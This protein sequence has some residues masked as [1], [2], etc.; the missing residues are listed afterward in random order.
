[1]KKEHKWILIA[2]IAYSCYVTAYIFN[3]SDEYPQGAEN[4]VIS[5]ETSF[6][7][8]GRQTVDI[9][10]R[11]Q[12]RD[13]APAGLRQAVNE[14]TE[15][16]VRIKT[17]TRID[18]VLVPDTVYISDGCDTIH[19]SKTLSNEWIQVAIHARRDSIGFALKVYNDLTV[20]VNNRRRLLKPDEAR[21]TVQNCNP[22]TISTGEQ[23]WVLKRE[24]KRWWAWLLAGALTGAI[25][26]QQTR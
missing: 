19:I 7:E 20:S 1:M 25:I 18:T 10:V 5:R 3:K 21:I 6:D 4:S 8:N 13:M 15:S 16:A 24:K 12:S 17:V 26:T 14:T 2:L 22:Y 9:R 23:V 11:R